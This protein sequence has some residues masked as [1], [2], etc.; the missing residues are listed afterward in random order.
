MSYLPHLPFGLAHVGVVLERVAWFDD[1][2]IDLIGNQSIGQSV[3]PLLVV[4]DGDGGC[5]VKE[6]QACVEQV[7]DRALLE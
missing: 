6:I 3:S 7:V 4:G 2:G 5:S 1:K